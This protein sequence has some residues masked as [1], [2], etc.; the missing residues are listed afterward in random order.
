MTDKKSNDSRRKLLKSIAA[1]SGAVVAGKSLPESWSKPVVDSMLLPAH[2]TTTSN[3]SSVETTPAPTTT[4]NPS[5]VWSAQSSFSDGIRRDL[6]VYDHR[7]AHIVDNEGVSSISIGTESDY[8]FL[9]GESLIFGMA[10][11]NPQQNVNPPVSTTLTVTTDCSSITVTRNI[12]ETDDPGNG[13][14]T[15]MVKMT[16]P[17]GL[18]EEVDFTIPPP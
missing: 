4:C 2:A 1:G 11:Q 5:G 17:E 8:P 6:I 3:D 14:S 13:A 7:P 16:F 12:I 10:Y 18:L 9:K 15:A